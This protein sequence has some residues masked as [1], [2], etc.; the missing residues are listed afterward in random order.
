VDRVS[1]AVPYDCRCI[2]QEQ[3]GD[4]V[5]MDNITIL[6]LNDR[7]YSALAERLGDMSVRLH[8]VLSPCPKPG[9]VQVLWPYGEVL[10]ALE[11]DDHSVCD[12]VYHKGKCSL[13]DYLSCYLR[14]CQLLGLSVR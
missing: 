2:R 14:S 7:A 13:H 12:D 8:G 1:L 3:A 6:D 5:R 9:V 11:A 10:V 4:W